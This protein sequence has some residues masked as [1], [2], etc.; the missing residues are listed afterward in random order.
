MP[1]PIL[2][3]RIASVTQA[4][5]LGVIAVSGAD[6]A[7]APGWALKPDVIL[8]VRVPARPSRLGEHPTF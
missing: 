5:R 8:I 6:G 3:P 4:L 7:G 1:G 2:P